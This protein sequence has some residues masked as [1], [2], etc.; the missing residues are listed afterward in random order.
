M[1][2]LDEMVQEKAIFSTV[3]H[4]RLQ[5]HEIYAIQFVL[6]DEFSHMRQEERQ[7]L[8]HE[9]SGPRVISAFV[10]I[11][12]DNTD[13][14]LP[15]E[16]DEVSLRRVIGSKKDQFFLDKKSVTRNDVMNMLEGAGFSRSNPYYIVKQ[17]KINQLATAKDYERLKLLREVAGTRVYDERKEESQRILNETEIKKE[18]IKEL[19]AYIDDR[20][21][22]LQVEMDELKQYQTL[23]KDRRSIEYTIHEKELQATRA[24]LEQL[25][26]NREDEM[27][28]TAKL[29]QD[30]AEALDKIEEL[31]DK[32]RTLKEKIR[33]LGEQ[34]LQLDEERSEIVQNKTKLELDIKDFEDAKEGYRSTKQ[35]YELELKDIRERIEK[36]QEELENML[37]RFNKLKSTEE[38][39]SLR[40][41]VCEQRRSQLFSKQGRT[42]QFQS[43]QQRDEWINNE[44]K[45][46]AKSISTKESQILA[47]QET[48]KHLNA[49]RE[50]TEKA[51]RVIKDDFNE[52]RK[53][54]DEAS[55]KKHALTKQRDERTNKRKELWRVEAEL[56]QT[57]ETYK[58]DLYRRERV[59]RSSVSK[60][61]LNGIESVKTIVR[62]EGIQGYHGPLIE[63]FTCLPRFYTAV[64]VTAGNKLFHLLVDS[65]KIATDILKI[66]NRRKM[67]GSATFMP[68]NK[69]STR[70]TDF[71]IHND[72]FPMMRELKFQQKFRPAMLTVFGKTLVCRDIDVAS[73]YS[74]S[75]N[76]DCVTMEGDQVSRR[77]ALTGGYYDSRKSRLECQRSLHEV[78]AKIDSC[79]SQKQEIRKQLEQIDGEVTSIL[80]EL[81]KIESKL[82]MQKETNDQQKVNVI[83][84]QKELQDMEESLAHKNQLLSK[85]HGDLG[86]MK[87][88]KSSLSSE[89][90]TELMTRLSNED[91]NE[92]DVINEEIQQLQERL[93]TTLS[94]RSVLE[95]Q[96]NKLENLL[97]NNLIKRRDKLLQE[98]DEMALEGDE[99]QLTSMRE[100]LASLN[101]RHATILERLQGI[102]RRVNEVTGE[103][104]ATDDLLED[105]K[106]KE[107]ESQL[108][109]NDDS[110]SVEKIA[111][112]KSVLIKKKDDCMKKIRELGSLPSNA[113]EKY[114][115]VN[116][117]ALWKKLQK[118]NEDLKKYSHVN[119]KALDQFVNFSEQKEALTKRRDEVDKGYMAITD[120]IDVLDQRKNEAILF[121]FKQVSY[122]FT[123]VFKELVPRGKANLVMKTGGPNPDDDSSS[124]NSQGSD[125]TG[126]SQSQSRLPSDKFTGVSIKVSFTGKSAETREMNQLSGGQKSLVALALIFAIQRCDP[127]PFYLFDEIDQALD[128]QYR[129]S[130]AEMI[131][132][133]AEKA[134]FITT[135]F[136]VELLE[137]SDKFYGVRFRNKVSHIDVIAK[138]E[139]KEFVESDEHNAAGD[140]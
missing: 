102:N 64:E 119:K 111:S 87:S 132:K 57:V 34:E 96:K 134:Q 77:G 120:L 38:E 63:N 1:L 27:R 42:N 121:T 18:K 9:G 71:P 130:V 118:C 19:L 67:P 97:T 58:E 33:D 90:G 136:R 79:E 45:S 20:L 15:M 108:R 73:Q 37:P 126:G 46:L 99:R 59:L 86:G 40:M 16:K 52:I 31:T 85:M 113:F 125:G 110:K 93:R 23:D 7:A 112:K 21:D 11:I 55:E 75:A 115:A 109:L 80:G 60:A 66:M 39:C 65:D 133:Q 53:E 12:F 101:S 131:K 103:V 14:R 98:L 35:N 43:K 68:L 105:W 124:R 76:L 8:L 17:G 41:E 6:S 72:V 92:V 95:P 89:L 56:D 106:N 116:V 117:K 128:P 62:D 26:T 4:F 36:G 88:S 84:K 22:T 61:I 78:R 5:P 139:A 54:I 28:L 137:Y 91:Q 123:A 69:L 29:R 50:N 3:K 44:L 82:M 70:E 13:N 74:K 129:T 122:H 49:S 100:E 51:V 81:Q 114:Q 140:S 104:K 30:V 24:K 2:L 32:A 94:E 10:E 138:E 83:T 25:E 48:I 135:T 47:L 127:A 107:K